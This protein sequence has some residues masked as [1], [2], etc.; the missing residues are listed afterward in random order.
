MRK[1]L[2]FALSLVFVAFTS[3]A[4]ITNGGFETW[5][6]ANPDGWGGTKTATSGLTVTKVTT[7]AHGGT[8]ACSLKN[9]TTSHKRFTSTA[10]SVTNGTSYEMSFWIKGTGQVRTGMYTS[11]A[12]AASGYIAYNVYVSA[13]ADWTQVTQ[14]LVSD[15]DVSV[16]EFIISVGASADV[17]IDDVTVGGGVLSNEANIVSFSI[18]QQTGDATIDTTAKTVAI[19]VISGTAV[20]ALIPTIT[21]SSAATISPATG[22]AQDFTNPVVYTVTAQDGTTSKQFTVTVS[23]SSVLSAE[24]DIVAFSLTQQAS[25]ATIDAT[26]KTVVIKVVPGTDVTALAP[27]IEVSGGATVSPATGVAQDFTNP[28]IYTVTAQDGTT[29]KEFT[30]TVEIQQATSIYDIQF[31]TA[32][33]ADSPLLGQTVTLSGVTVTAAGTAGYYVQDAEGAYNGVY[34]YDNVN[35]PVIGDK[36]SLTALVAEY[37]GLTELTTI[38]N[39]SKL[40]SGNPVLAATITT[41]QSATEGYEG[42]LVT[43]KYAKCTVAPVSGTWTVNDGSGDVKVFKTLF[44][45]TTATLNSY[46]DITGV[47][48]WY[49]TGGIYELLPR[50][51][52]DVVASAIST[53]KNIVSFVLAEQTATSTIDATAGTVA[54]TVFAGTNVT[55]LVPTIGVSP[56]ATISPASGVA[57]DFTN[58]VVYTVTA[59][60]GSTKT[61]TVTVTVSSVVNTEANIVS[62]TVTDQIG[63]ATINST[64][65]TVVIKLM[66]DVD[67]TALVPTFVLSAGATISPLVAQN[68][69]SPV[70]YTVTAQDGTTTKTWTVSVDKTYKTIFEIQNAT[71]NSPLVG[72]V[73]VTTGTVCGI[74]NYD[75]TS[76]LMMGYFLQSGKGA[77]TGIYV[78]S[79]NAFA[80]GDSIFLTGKVAE[81][82][83][84]TIINEVTASKLAMPGANVYVNDV[85]VAQANSESFE[86]CL[87]KVTNAECSVALDTYG[88]WKVKQGTDEVQV[89]DVLLALGAFDALGITVGTTYT[90]TGFMYFSY[91]KFNILPSDIANVIVIGIDEVTI[92]NI[93]LYPNPVSSTLNINNIK[94]FSSIK[95]SN[96]LGQNVANVNVENAN[97]QVNFEGLNKGI[98]FVSL[99]DKNE[100][101]KTFKVVKN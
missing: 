32:S 44:D 56:A 54:I 28:V 70:T 25:A 62:A 12:A 45:Y 76:G 46:Y 18:P 61:F 43:V 13:T 73:V 30:V 81:K 16:A 24:A 35:K 64:A 84:H 36:V 101:V 31:S 41:A 42:V 15:G 86:S 34:I 91:S 39:Y 5:T 22:V 51:A 20:T 74:K 23:I 94:D 87:I 4:Q 100:L 82:F 99:Y 59:Q 77:F 2:L 1:I 33:P 26:A 60:D 14:T 6:A 78:E 85:T 11:I 50:S 40:S 52:A 49:S 10:T 96:L 89:D 92:N 80:I 69:T 97:V 68:F 9:T 88:V 27:T 93:D 37:N 29:I 65:G 95:V 17:V 53:E 57:Q 67:V 63:N 98:Y 47:M 8:N 55:A 79:P 7:A 90:I 3:N 19:E 71:G 48:T 66:P 83:S 75:S 38:T 21:I 58:P 72:Q